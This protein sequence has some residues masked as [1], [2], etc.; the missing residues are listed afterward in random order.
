MKNSPT[1]YDIRD[2]GQGLVLQGRP[3]SEEGWFQAEPQVEPLA[4]RRIDVASALT[5]AT[6]G[7]VKSTLAP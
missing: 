3:Y 6:W 2:D 4:Y 7:G 1:T 5:P